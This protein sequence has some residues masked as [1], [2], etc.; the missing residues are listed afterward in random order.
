MTKLINEIEIIEK[1]I[2]DS[3]EEKRM[4]EE[5]KV[6][7]EI[8]TNPKVF[9]RYAKKKRVIKSSVGP[10]LIDGKIVREEKAMANILTNHYEKICSIPRDD[11][12]S[13]EFKKYLMD[14]S[15]IDGTCYPIMS[16]ILID[17][18]AIKKII[19][20]LS[21]NAAMGHDGLPVHIFKYGGD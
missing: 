5:E 11:I 13:D 10:F 18:E 7:D 3:Y 21:N 4:K 8:K 1:K 14:N 17:K 19:N 12:D 2:K 6:I 16:D 20:K 15:D 9:Y